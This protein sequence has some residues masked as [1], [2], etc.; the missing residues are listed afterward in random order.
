MTRSN[1]DE[2]AGSAAD[3]RVRR[4]G[5]RSSLSHS[6]WGLWLGSLIVA[7]SATALVTVAGAGGT[8]AQVPSAIQVGSQARAVTLIAPKPKVPAPTLST[9]STRPVATPTTKTTTAVTDRT[10]VINPVSTV[11]DQGDS[12]GGE[13]AGNSRTVNTKTTTKTAT[14]PSTSVDN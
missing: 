3:A 12:G 5:R 11:T 8:A 10:K 6:R 13:N 7:A 2:A 1:A 4:L 9:P 14:T